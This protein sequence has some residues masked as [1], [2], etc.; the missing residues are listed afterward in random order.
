M[1]YIAHKHYK[2]LLAGKTSAAYEFYSQ[3]H[4]KQG[5]QHYAINSKLYLRTIKDKGI[6]IH[7]EFIS[8]LHIYVKA[9]R[10]FGKRLFTNFD[11]NNIEIGRDSKFH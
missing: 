2:S 6:E 1:H 4:G 10:I 11:Y 7:N 9:I 5:I 3:M 8:Q